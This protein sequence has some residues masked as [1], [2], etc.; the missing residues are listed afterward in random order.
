MWTKALPYILVVV[1][2]LAILGGVY[3][4]GAKD[5]ETKIENKQLNAVVE[6]E[7]AYDRKTKEVIPL[8]DAALRERYCKWV[9]DSKELC[10]QADI[11]LRDGRTD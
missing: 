9:R 2:V 10:L 8:G 1:A 7:K 4:W 5:T 11:P 3:H 6:S